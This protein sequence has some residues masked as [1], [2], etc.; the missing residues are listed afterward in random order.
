MIR[1]QLAYEFADLKEL[2]T[3]I[4][5]AGPAGK[6]WI[7]I[8]IFKLFTYQMWVINCHKIRSLDTNLMSKVNNK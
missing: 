1:V 5:Q 6:D 7:R 4:D 8:Y 3:Q 2:D